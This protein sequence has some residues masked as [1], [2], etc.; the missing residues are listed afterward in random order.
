MT[1]TL[2]KN[3][4]FFSYRISRRNS[5]ETSITCQ[6]IF[7][8][9]HRTRSVVPYQDNFTR[10]IWAN[11]YSPRKVYLCN[12]GSV[13]KHACNSF[14]CAHLTARNCHQICK[15]QIKAEQFHLQNSSTYNLLVSKCYE[16]GYI[17]WIHGP[18]RVGDEGAKFYLRSIIHS[19]TCHFTDKLDFRNLPLYSNSWF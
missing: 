2:A 10:L 9:F 14:P 8:H 18:A 17:N 4:R 1:R 19:P 15:L 3:R 11:T 5:L 7:L 16:H 6:W 12:M 13:H